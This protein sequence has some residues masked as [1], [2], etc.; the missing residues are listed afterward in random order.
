MIR[1]S[2]DNIFIEDEVIELE[3]DLHDEGGIEIVGCHMKFGTTKDMLED[4]A[5]HPDNNIDSPE[6][7]DPEVKRIGV[8][9]GNFRIEGQVVFI[10]GPM[11]DDAPS[12]VARRCKVR[13]NGFQLRPGFLQGVYETI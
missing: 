7:F 11:P 4:L 3:S 1:I 2:G 5:V 10:E 6:D 13:T 9:K 8:Y 12:L